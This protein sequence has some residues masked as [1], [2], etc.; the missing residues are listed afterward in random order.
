MASNTP[1]L[2]LYM[3]DDDGSEP[4]NVATDLNDNLEKLDASTGFVPATESTPPTGVFSGM[5][6]YNTDSGKASFWNAIS[7]TWT[8]ILTAGST[9]LSNLLL[10]DSF[11]IGIGAAVPSAIIDVVINNVFATPLLK[12]KQTSEAFH[13]FEINHDG[14]R[15]GGGSALPETR[16]YRPAPNQINI[17]GSVALSND[18]SVTGATAVGNLDV[19]GDLVLGGSVVGDLTVTADMYVD[20]E[21]NGFGINV[22]I[23]IRKTANATRTNTTVSAVDADF[24]FPLLANSSY[25]VE[26]ILVVAGPSDIKIGYNFPTGTTGTRW[27]LGMPSTGTNAN[28]TTM[29][30]AATGITAEFVYG[31]HNSTVFHHL[32]DE[33]CINTSATAGTLQFKWAQGVANAVAAT[34]LAN[35]VMRITRVA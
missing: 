32:R 15:I 19:S 27:L 31:T 14:I 9:F 25:L 7:S 26:L 20:G 12:Y 16:I 10:G 13:R 5:G 22:P 18:L 17:V 2:G 35:S 30:T 24:Q 23:V 8:Q 33:M 1:R 28:D 21:L 4:I 11:R 29:N 3:P 6:R 34:I